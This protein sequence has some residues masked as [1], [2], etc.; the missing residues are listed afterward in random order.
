MSIDHLSERVLREAI[1]EI[2]RTGS[3]DTRELSRRTRLG[4]ERLEELLESIGLSPATR[5]EIDR[6]SL[7]LRYIELGGDPETVSQYLDWRD[8]EKF[9]EE[10]LDRYGY[11]IARGVRAPPPRGFEID[12]LALDPVK[13]RL[14]VVDCKHWRR[15][16]EAELREVARDLIERVERL[17]RR[18]VYVSR[19]HP[20]VA[21][22][23]TVVPVIVTLRTT[24]SRKIG[25]SVLVSPVGLFRDLIERLD[26][27]IEALEVRPLRI[28]CRSLRLV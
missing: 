6:V 17:A 2:L 28:S 10:I 9:I 3:I 24:L 4:V 18:C 16:R 19:T 5:Q 25:E 1:L 26:E 12:V 13:R 11:T 22:A 7:A 27:Y 8:F 23:E 15:S 20:W 14:L 21:D